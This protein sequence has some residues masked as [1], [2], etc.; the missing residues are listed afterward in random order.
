MVIHRVIGHFRALAAAF[1]CAASFAAP[2]GAQT[3]ASSPAAKA[4]RPRVA[5]VLS[6]GGARGLAHIGVLRVL[7]EMH[8]PVDIVV[9]TSMGAVVGGAYAAGRTVDELARITRET[10]W[11][12]VLSDR[13]VRDTL[14]YRRREEDVLL[15]S[16]IEFA[17][18]KANGV[19]LPPAAAS[20]AAIEEA[21]I[22]L[23]PAGMRDRRVDQLALPFRSVASDL[24]SGELVELADTSLFLALRASLAVPGVFAPVR[25]NDRLVVDG[26]LVRNLPVDMARAMGADVVIAVNVGTPLAPEEELGSAIGVARQMLQI[27]T[28]QNVQRS[29]KELGADDILIAP[30]L[31][32]ITFLDFALHDKAMRAGEAAARKLADRLR[33]LAVPAADY[34]AFEGRRMA[35]T[36]AD[37]ANAAVAR[38][39][40][41][42]E[43]DGTRHVNPEALLAQSGLREGQLLTPGQIRQATTRL[44]GRGDIDNVETVIRDEADGRHVTIRPTEATWGRNRLR[45]GLELASD[46]SDDN[47][48]SLGLMHVASSLNRYGAELRTIARIGTERELSMQFWQPLG[49]GSPWFLAPSIEYDGLPINVYNNGLRA[50]RLGIRSTTATLAAGRELARWG[51]FQFGLTRRFGKIDALIPEQPAAPTVRFYETTVFGRFRIDT[52]DSLAFPTRGQLITALWERAPT[53]QAGQPTLAQSSIVGLTAFEAGDWAAHLYGEWSRASAGN[54]PQSLGG[55]LRLSGTS[56]DS[57]DGNKIVFGRAVFARKIGVMPA[58]IGNA[59]RLG[60]SVELGGGFGNGETVRFEDLKRAGSVFV[61]ADTRFGP[62]YFGAGGTKGNGG[63]LYLFLGPIW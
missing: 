42:V 60:F 56:P 52:L 12:N 61:A 62:L 58:T 37:E 16:R 57:L 32:G 50:Y 38:P 3:E 36:V 18:T 33:K 20:N 26:G 29:I 54:A 44:Y 49:A 25:V 35:P 48:F 43:V 24:V 55:F 1:L 46:F 21:L 4:G 19:S 51:D 47:S 45:A 9:G 22:R 14:D 28:E 2:A 30:D 41:S 23:L 63:T 17:V 6:G 59:V 15:P 53:R 10:P 39:L 27:L 31:K 5:L 8:V 40:A 7:K 34:I 13:P 11:H